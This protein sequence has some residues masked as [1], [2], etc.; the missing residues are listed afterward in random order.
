MNKNIKWWKDR[1]KENNFITWTIGTNIYSY[2]SF[3]VLQW[4]NEVDENEEIIL[5]ID[6]KE[7]LAEFKNNTQFPFY[8]DKKSKSDSTIRQILDVLSSLGIIEPIGDNYKINK[9]LIDVRKTESNNFYALKKFVKSN[10]ANYI[11]KFVIDKL[12]DIKEEKE[13]SN[14]SIETKFWWNV[15]VVSDETLFN[16]RLKGIFNTLVK[17]GN[18]KRFYEDFVLEFLYKE[19]DNDDMEKIISDIKNITGIEDYLSILYEVIDNYEKNIV[20]YEDNSLDEAI[21]KISNY[22]TKS[23]FEV[24]KTSVKDIFTSQELK[25][26]LPLYQRTYS[27]DSNIIIG[28]FESIY[29]DFI[30][31]KQR[32]NDFSFLNNIIIVQNATTNSI[33]DGQQRMVS[34]IIIIILLYKFSKNKFFENAQEKLIH[35]IPKIKE[36][37]TEFA[38]DD[39]NYLSLQNI[40]NSIKKDA[41][42]QKDRFYENSFEIINLIVKKFD[43]KDEDFLLDFIDY[44]L[45]KTFLITTYIKVMDDDFVTKIFQN[46]NQYSKKLGVLDLLRNKVFDIYRD[47]KENKIKLYNLTVN[48]YFRR[49]QKNVWNEDLK[50]ISNF[51]DAVFIKYRLFEELER[52]NKKFYDE[53]ANCYNK[54]ENLFEYYNSNF[55]F[56]DKLELLWKDIIEFEYCSTGHF[57]KFSTLLSDSEIKENN[58]YLNNFNAILTEYEQKI[59]DY[60]Q[61]NFQIN[62]ISNSGSKTI[63]TQLIWSLAYNLQLFENEENTEKMVIFSKYLAEIEKFSALW[64]IRFAGQSLSSSIK[65][66]CK[67]DLLNSDFNLINESKLY[68]LLER[69]IVDL[70]KLSLVEKINELWKYLYEKQNSKSDNKLYKNIIAKVIYSLQNSKTPKSFT[71]FKSQEEKYQSID[72]IPYTYEHNFPQKLDQS[73]LKNLLELGINREQIERI[74][75]LIGNGFLLLGKDNSK[76]SNKTTKNYKESNIENKTIEGFQNTDFYLL[77]FEQMKTSNS[78]KWTNNKI[79]ISKLDNLDIDKISSKDEFL[80]L[81]NQ[82]EKRTKEIIEAYISILFYE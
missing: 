35:L 30:N 13:I 34:L 40:F 31:T 50:K 47:E 16:D 7:V 22:S 56:E 4:L 8:K 49:K 27:W 70:T 37:I 72:F 39:S 17:V 5:T 79:Q 61:V 54:F 21:K 29:N 67:N 80:E 33:V 81:L 38:K 41:Q 66:I 59:Y 60:K 76:F 62:N 45:N 14:S 51:L 64:E 53:I 11:K 74:T 10:F 43:K 25:Y 15:L 65:L 46:L 55:E 1:M 48:I 57:N 52:T 78:I 20:R 26:I 77:D 32:K 71:G 3:T 44:I 63:F 23:E 18:E 19:I 82:R 75:N 9:E 6:K 68:E 69:I 28:L 2:L 12:R 36:M 42:L 24:I 73:T 58:K